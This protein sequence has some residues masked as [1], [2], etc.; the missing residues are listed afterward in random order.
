MPVRF[1]IKTSGGGEYL[2]DFVDR[3]GHRRARPFENRKAAGQD[4]MF[5]RGDADG[6]GTVNGLVDGLF[7]LNFQFIPGSPEPPCLDAADADDS[8]SVNGLVDGLF[9]LNFQF[10]GGAPPPDPGPMSCGE[11]PTADAT[12]CA[13]PPVCP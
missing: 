5:L 13:V 9:I 7:V 10:A 1:R 3:L 4:P 2:V 12:L 11:D 6:D 8:G